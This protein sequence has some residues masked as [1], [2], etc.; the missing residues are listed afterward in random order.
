LKFAVTVVA[1]VVLLL[2]FV[3][4]WDF[5]RQIQPPNGVAAAVTFHRLSDLLVSELQPYDEVGRRLSMLQVL[6]NDRSELAHFRAESRGEAVWLVFEPAGWEGFECAAPVMSDVQQR[7]Y[8][9]LPTCGLT[10]TPTRRDIP[11]KEWLDYDP[12]WALGFTSEVETNLLLMRI[13]TI[14]AYESVVPDVSAYQR[15]DATTAEMRELFTLVEITPADGGLKLEV[16][17]ASGK[18]CTVFV[19]AFSGQRPVVGPERP[20]S[21]DCR[22]MTETGS[23]LEPVR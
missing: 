20:L 1:L 6:L 18:L 5:D 16:E 23:I 7:A 2:P 14:L 3:R 22:R 9:G 17:T 13:R 19:G 10:A 8:T 21:L 15:L 12:S 11:G 4:T